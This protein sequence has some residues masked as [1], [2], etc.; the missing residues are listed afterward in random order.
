[1]NSARLMRLRSFKVLFGGLTPNSLWLG[2][3]LAISSTIAF[4]LVTPL[5]KIALNLGVHPTTLLVLRFGIAII[6]LFASIGLMAPAKLRIDRK[7][8]LI[9]GAAG[10]VN[11]LGAVA[12]FWSL[13]R[14]DASVATMIYSLYPLLVLGLLALRGE[15]LTYRHLI[16]LALGLTGVYLLIGPGGQ[17][18]WLGALVIL[19][20]ICGV[21]TELVLIQWF[22]QPYDA[23][24][25][26]LYVLT[27][28]FL[29]MLGMWLWQ[30][31]GWQNPIWQA[32]LVL[33]FI[34]VMGTFLPWVAMFT[35]IRHIGSGQLVLL[36]PLETLLT[37]IWAFIFLS[38]SFS[39]WQT[40]GGVLILISALLAVQRLK[41]VRWRFRWRA[42]LRV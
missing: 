32:W 11:G 29:S 4:S 42:T 21:A 3:A 25:I 13:T 16:R 35:S 28:M 41:R 27:G 14:L 15:K 34:A 33:I 38:E 2:W 31:V 9:A 8:F 17:V 39:F 12:F 36:G 23:R 20:S 5:G 22:L 18:D 1:M 37:V 24:T 40:I 30:D 19:L 7:G 10:L 6:L 26:T